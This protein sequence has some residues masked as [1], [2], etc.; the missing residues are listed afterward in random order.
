MYLLKVGT[1]VHHTGRG[2]GH[3]AFH[4]NAVPATLRIDEDIL[5]Y[6]QTHYGSSNGLYNA[7]TDISMGTVTNGYVRCGKF[8]LFTRDVQYGRI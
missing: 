5:I 1:F 8:V 3:I 4:H 6:G 7:V 2:K